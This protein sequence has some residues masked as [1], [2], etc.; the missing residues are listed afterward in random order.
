MAEDGR[1]GAAVDH[2][3][4][5]VAVVDDLTNGVKEAVM[6]PSSATLVRGH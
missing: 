2:D 3:G 5:A 1:V 6:D 4:D